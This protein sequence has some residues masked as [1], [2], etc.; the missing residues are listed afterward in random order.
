MRIVI[1]FFVLLL[2]GVTI[3]TVMRI[4]SQKGY[5]QSKKSVSQDRFYKYPNI[6]MTNALIGAV[7]V[8][9]IDKKKIEHNKGI[10]SMINEVLFQL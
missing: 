3:R 10:C 7:K 2:H 9:S 1:I 4:L 8:L 5:G 6:I